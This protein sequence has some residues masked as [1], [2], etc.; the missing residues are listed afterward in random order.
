LNVFL[1][2]ISVMRV[3]SNEKISATVCW[4]QMSAPAVSL[5][6]LTIMAQPTFEEEHPDLTRFQR[7]HRVL[8]LPGMHFMFILALIGMASSLHS[9]YVRWASF[10]KKEFSPAH[11]AFCFPVLAHANAVQ[12]YRGAID[13]FSIIKPYSPFKMV[14]YSYWVVVLVCGTIA[15]IIITAKFFYHLPEWTQVDVTDEEEPP[16]PNET[17]MAEVINQGHF[18]SMKQH[19]VSP[20]VLQANETGALIRA[21]DGHF[22][23]TR[24][25]RALGFEPTMNW[26]EMNDEREALLQ[27]ALKFPP[28]RRNRTLSVPGIN[29]GAVFGQGH[30]GVY[31]DL[32]AGGMG[33][34]GATAFQHLANTSNAPGGAGVAGGNSNYGTA[35]PTESLHPFASSARRP[36]S[37]TSDFVSRN[38]RNMY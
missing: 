36:R 19:F 17:M 14:L 32:E 10:H 37:Q 31:N 8:Y 25:V 15:T 1:F 34:G 38:D 2:P 29:V 22:V 20:A 21:G 23:R 18:E 33:M 27:W 11:A 16:Q 28:R 13:A 26:S 24:R 7:L 5:Y 30:S 9:L 4:I 6:A 35:D 3:W 12:A